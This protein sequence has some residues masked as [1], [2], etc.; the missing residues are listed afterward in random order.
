MPPDSFENLEKATKLYGESKLVVD[1]LEK[2]KSMY[3]LDGIR[4]YSQVLGRRLDSLRL[5]AGLN[6]A[7]CAACL[8]ES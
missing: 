6:N 4:T 7:I 2:S 8:L 5:H 1:R 3:R